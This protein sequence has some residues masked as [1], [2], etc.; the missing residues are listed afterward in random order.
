MR[1]YIIRHADP[2][3][4]KDTITSAGHLEARALATRLNSEGITRIYV[5]S[6]GRAIDTA[7]YTAERLALDYVV[8]D[9]LR[10]IESF[11]VDRT[12]FGSSVAW[13]IPGTTI[14]RRPLPTQE[15][16]HDKAPFDNPVFQKV[17]GEIRRNSDGF[18]SRH[19]YERQD[20]A[21]I[22]KASNKERIAVFCHLGFGMTWLAHLLDLPVP[23]VWS[24]F[25]LAPS[26]VTTVLFDERS[27][28]LATPRCLSVGDTAHL[29]VAGLPVQPAGIIANYD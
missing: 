14:R 1:L 28:E 20:G 27:E 7:R 3:Y 9:W 13:N 26:S 19:G 24:G 10:E 29:Q 17:F 18:L 6:Y 11:K 4:A 16:W 8:Q 23:L 5:S 25:F 12:A 21:Y 15:H 2:D 22:I